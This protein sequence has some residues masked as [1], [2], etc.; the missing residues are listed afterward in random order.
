M[1]AWKLHG[2]GTIQLGEVVG[3]DERLGW[4]KMFGLGA[5]HVVAMFGATFLVP[6]IT[7]FPVTT[8]LFFSGLGTLL[9]LLITG[10]RLPSYLGSSFAFISPVIAASSGK[11]FS[12]ALFGI[13]LTGILLAIVGTVVHLAGSAWIDALM[14]PVMTGTIVMLIGFNLAS[15]AWMSSSQKVV[16]DAAGKCVPDP[17]T[18]C[19]ITTTI[20]GGFAAA[21]LT[22]WITVIAI[23]LIAVL[24]KGLIGRLSILL[25]VL[26]GYVAALLQGQVDFKTVGEAAWF[27]LPAFSLPTVDFGVAALFLPVVLV[28][29]A[30]NVGH[31]KSVSLM[32]G[33][34]YDKTMG[35][36]L[37]AD[38]VATTLAGLGGGSG[39]TTYA[40]NIG[41][42]AAT[43]VYSTALYWIAGCFAIL[44]SFIPKFGAAIF[45]IPGGVIGA[46]GTVLYGMIGL[47]GARIWIE[48][49]VVFTNPVNLIPAAVGLIMGIANFTFTLG[50]M[51]F[52]GVT[53]GTV[54]A[55]V[56]YHLMRGIAKARGTDISEKADVSFPD[57]EPEPL[58]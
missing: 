32:T 55:L 52:G 44:L 36:A 46:A 10:N 17:A 2:N 8:T 34:N 19:Q 51:T 58:A 56:L 27:G 12:R 28:L 45:T 16:L 5:Q 42:M 4:G 40:E 39:T 54:T 38:G 43:K 24:F 29:I 3:P 49:K 15:A 53:V 7:G 22:G 21:P 35:R 18:G 11:D 26:V 25:G 31:V 13:M 57:Y 9:F 47:L 41:V 6:L 20:T 33:K 30:E 23:V 1:A 37:L 48:N 14:P 50:G